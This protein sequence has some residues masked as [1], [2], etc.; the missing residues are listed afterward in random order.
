M[1]IPR[2]T[3]QH[4]QGACLHY[5]AL[6]GAF[7]WRQNSG[8]MARTDATTGKRYY[9]RFNGAPGCSDIIGVYRGRFLAVEVKQPGQR[10][11]VEQQVF[12]DSVRTCGGIALVVTS[13]DDLQQQLVEVSK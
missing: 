9:T 6:I 13:V 12:L 10:P 7:A 2:P 3:E 11:T 5:L 8:A 1:S 4:I